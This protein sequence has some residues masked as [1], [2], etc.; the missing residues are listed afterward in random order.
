MQSGQVT[1]DVVVSVTASAVHKELTDALEKLEDVSQEGDQ[2]RAICP[3]HG[4]HGLTIRWNDK[5][6]ILVVH[7]HAGCE[8]DEVVSELRKLGI[9][10]G[11][12]RHRYEYRDEH[13]ALKWTKVRFRRKDGTPGT[14]FM[15][16][17]HKGSVPIEGVHLGKKN[18][19]PDK[20]C[21][22]C[23]SSEHPSGM[24]YNVAAVI[25]AVANGDDIWLVDGEKDVDALTA[26]GVIATSTMNGNSDWLPVYVDQLTGAKAVVIVADNDA[27]KKDVGKRRSYDRYLSLTGHVETVCVKIAKVGKDS[28]DHLNAGYG[29]KDFVDVPISE[30]EA[31]TQLSNGDPIDATDPLPGEP[32]TQYG[33]ALR[34]VELHGLEVVYDGRWWR[35]WDGAYWRKDEHGKVL[36]MSARL[37][38]QMSHVSETV[39]GPND[40]PLYSAFAAKQEGAGA[41]AST[42]ALAKSELSLPQEEFDY[43]TTLL[44]CRSGIYAGGGAFKPHDPLKLYTKCVPIEHDPNATCPEWE[45]FLHSSIPDRDQRRYLQTLIGYALVGGDRKKKRIVNLIGP[46]DTGKS[47]FLRYIGELLAPYISTPAVEELVS[48]KSRRQS[49]KFAL[50]ELRGSRMAVVSEIESH[51]TFRVAPLKALT[52][53]DVIQTQS[54]NRDPVEWRA[55]IMLLIA[56]NERIAFDITDDAF[57]ERQID[58]VFRRK[59]K[60]D[61]GLSAKLD[62][63]KAGIWNWI[64]AGVDSYLR[65]ELV[66]PKSVKE[67]RETAETEISIPFQFIQAG[68]MSGMI[69]AVPPTF[70]DAKCCQVT[71]LY[72]HYEGWCH[73]EGIRG[74]PK[75]REFSRIV[76][77][78]YRKRENASDGK[79]HFL[80]IAPKQ[81]TGK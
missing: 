79:N 67:A 10:L 50:S 78:R 62:A 11:S 18:T 40:K 56:T 6:N 9:H 60:I 5:S 47:T 26:K 61:R 16:H 29:L 58:I 13:G 49:D 43:D 52:G 68:L 38:R 36:R 55:S 25:S 71:T 28:Y 17:S 46:K 1:E 76:Q 41:I 30:L 80:G 65:D 39:L 27:K 73:A 37:S 3:V 66:E 64:L 24:L 21:R 72:A 51:S 63:E 48:H 70:P 59:R 42:M 45:R 32:W 54:K 4:G 7:C 8:K 74:Y 77:R 15:C 81:A 2:Y 31:L 19:K 69:V 44:V 57:A 22:L 75:L 20:T 33:Y 35:Y 53:G 34:F 12:A 23:G 14:Y